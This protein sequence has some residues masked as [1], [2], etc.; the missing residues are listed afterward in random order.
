[1]ANDGTANTSK[2]PAARL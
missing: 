1:M 2:S